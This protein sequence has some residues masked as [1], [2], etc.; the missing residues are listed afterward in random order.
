MALQLGDVAPDFSQDST[1]GSISFH[2]YI[3]DSWC[4]LFSH[5]KDFTPVCTTELGEVAKLKGEFAKR[6]CKVIAVSVDSVEDHVKWSDDVEEIAGARP[7]YPILAD[8]DRKVADLYGMIHPKA[9][10]TLTVRTV[11]W[12]SPEKK[13]R[14]MITYPAPTGRNFAE[15]LRVLDALQLTD[16]YMVATPVNWTDGGACIIVPSLT[17]PEVM[18]EKFPKGWD[19]KRPYFRTTP[20]PNR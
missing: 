12:I 5:P 11:F 7:N 14:A 15:I 1:E 9:L 20:Q 10:D 16:E 4:I 3:G 6:N 17:D 8:P 13:I 2:N 19:E 18:K